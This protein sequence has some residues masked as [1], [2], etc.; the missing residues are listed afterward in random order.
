MGLE[1]QAAQWSQGKDHEGGRGD[2]PGS[3]GQAG[4]EGEDGV[5]DV[6]PKALL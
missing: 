2:E 6:F 3:H 1:S 4:K 5:H